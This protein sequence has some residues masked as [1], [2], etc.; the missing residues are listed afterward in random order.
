[1]KWLISAAAAAALF[2]GAE[3]AFAQAQRR[4]A[5]PPRGTLEGAGKTKTATG[6]GVRVRTG[7]A[8]NA[9]GRPAA[10]P[11]RNARR[12]LADLEK[13]HRIRMAKLERLRRLAEKLGRTDQLRRIA[14]AKQKEM[15][16]Y[17]ARKK[18]ILERARGA[19]SRK[20]GGAIDP[21]RAR[22]ERREA[23][24]RMEM[25]RRRAQ[26]RKEMEERRRRAAAEKARRAGGGR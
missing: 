1:M 2:A 12:A 17:Q 23:A 20:K 15:R 14:A 9:P 4:Q 5:E 16:I 11:E 7:P 22:A 21:A 3:G 24:E 8:V 25:Q 26:Q 13:T 19:A 10:G 18:A 6:R